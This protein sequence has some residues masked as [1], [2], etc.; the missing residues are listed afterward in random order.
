[1]RLVKGDWLMGDVEVGVNGL[2]LVAGFG[3]TQAPCDLVSQS[4]YRI[5]GMIQPCFNVFGGYFTPPVEAA[6]NKEFWPFTPIASLLLCQVR[7]LSGS[8]NPP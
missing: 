5:V 3:A 7:V 4:P 2:E 1:M 6:R 8:E